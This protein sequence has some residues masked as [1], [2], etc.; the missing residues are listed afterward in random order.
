M[1]DKRVVFIRNA[2]IVPAELFWPGRCND[3]D[4]VLTGEL[5][6]DHP[7]LGRK[8]GYPI[9]TSLIVSQ[10]LAARRIETRNT[11]YEVVSA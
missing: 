2:K 1:T 5:A 3:S 7:I 6:S 8:D 4:I 10:D 11:V 9:R